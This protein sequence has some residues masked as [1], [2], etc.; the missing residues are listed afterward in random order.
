MR[1]RIF[2][3][4]LTSALAIFRSIRLDISHVRGMLLGADLLAVTF[5]VLAVARVDLLPVLIGVLALLGDER[6]PVRDA[7]PGVSSAPRFDERLVSRG[8]ALESFTPAPVRF[9]RR[10]CLSFRPIRTK[11]WVALARAESLPF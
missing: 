6:F 10:G 11:C 4:A 2:R 7:S 5:G 8:I 9:V 3:V 1:L